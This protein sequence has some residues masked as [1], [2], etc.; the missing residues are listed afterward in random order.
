MSV[1]AR[2]GWQ[3]HLRNSRLPLRLMGHYKAETCRQEL[4]ECRFAVA[5]QLKE[6][7]SRS[8]VNIVLQNFEVL[9]C[10]HMLKRIFCIDN[11]SNLAIQHQ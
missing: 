9:K 7:A 5:E 3:I 6:R 11:K 2:S 1:A 4:T 10:L 8:A